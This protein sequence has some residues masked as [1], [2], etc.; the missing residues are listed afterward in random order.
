[1][2]LPLTSCKSQENGHCSWP[3]QYSRADPGD[4][5]TGKP[6]LRV[7]TQENWALPLFWHR[8]ALVQGEAL[9]V[10]RTGLEVVRGGRL[11]CLG[12]CSILPWQQESALMAKA[13]LSVLRV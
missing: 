7:R 12:T 6:V 2:S 9:V 1:M 10:W 4:G 13:W 8:V 11:L 3:G 5:D